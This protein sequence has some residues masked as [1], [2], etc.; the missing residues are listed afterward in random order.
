M[1]IWD[2]SMTW[3]EQILRIGCCDWQKALHYV[4]VVID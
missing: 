3:S 2:N 4:L 1:I